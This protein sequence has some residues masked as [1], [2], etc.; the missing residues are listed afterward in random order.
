MIR[1]KNEREIAGIRA[2]CHL[3]ADL[4]NDIIPRIKDGLTTAEV[5]TM[6]H[7]F[8]TQHGGKPAWYKEDFPG[9]ICISINDEVIHGVP[10][11]KRV[12]HTGDLVSLDIG[13]DLNGFISDSTHSILV[14]KAGSL[15]LEENDGSP[16]CAL[17]AA[18]IEALNAG[19]AACVAGNRIKDIADAVYSVAK[20]YN[21]GVVREYCGHGVGLD[22]H[23]DPEVPN[24]PDHCPNKRLQNGMVI[25]IEPMINMGGADVYTDSN[26]WTVKT[27]DGRP[28][29][30][31][32]HT[33]AIFSDHTEILTALDYNK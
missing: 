20:K 26:G 14:G 11:H 18:T 5:D 10:S 4:F 23:E 22:V 12:I 9:A 7:L 25:A 21:Y 8:M 30:H 33:V 3:L 31:E 24:T 27:L 32:E 2:S 6:C 29:C 13:I 1:L 19:I 17:H 15:V 28:S 16:L